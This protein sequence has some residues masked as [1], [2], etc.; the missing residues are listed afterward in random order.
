MSNIIQ[1][2]ENA[3]SGKKASSA[4][5]GTYG[6]HDSRAANTLDPRVDSDR[7]NSH[8]V[9]STTGARRTAGHGELGSAGVTGTYGAPEGTYGPH[10][11]RVANAMDPRVDSD[12]DNSRTVGGSGTNRTAGLGSSGATGFTGTHGA[13]EGT[14]GPHSS[15]VANAMDPRVDSDRDNS[16]TVGGT[17]AHRTAGLGSSGTTGFTGTHGAPEGTYGPH[18]SRVANAMDPRVDSDR[19]NSRTVGGTDAHRTAGLRNTGPAKNTA[20]PHKSDL[21]NKLDPRVDSDL[22]GSR[23][24]G[25]DKTFQ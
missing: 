24:L 21:L 3:I 10:S 11:S 6:P 9:G 23:T 25:Q 1:K 8:T 17:G 14:Y 12:R 4:P 16:R 19:D 20:G 22:D 15:R 2:I 18:S 13:P 5:E 7:D